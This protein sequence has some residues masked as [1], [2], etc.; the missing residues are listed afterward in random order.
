MKSEPEASG[1]GN[2]PAA[3]PLLPSSL[4]LA[5]KAKVILVVD[6]THNTR[7][8]LA[9]HLQQAGY[10]VWSAATSSEALT[11][12]AERGLPHL[13]VIDLQLGDR[14]GLLLAEL[15]QQ[16]GSLPVLFVSAPSSQPATAGVDLLF[17]PLSITQL[18]AR[19][20]QYLPDK[21]SSPLLG[22]EKSVDEHLTLNF[23]AH[24]AVL[25]Q[26]LI[27][28]TPAE[29]CLLALLFQYRGQVLSHHFLRAKLREVEPNA[30]RSVATYVYEL[31]QKLENHQTHRRY[32]RNVP[33]QG[34]VMPLRPNERQPAVRITI[35]G[36]GRA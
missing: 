30:R 21:L 4:A 36:R 11:V 25:G 13:V 23:A 9:F 12:V 22:Q 18:M 16:K 19:V 33:G 6:D 35:A 31:R 28:L 17:K 5:R 3:W 15:L 7:T 34:Y 32:I 14:S 24:Y 27:G 1:V 2:A 26:Q 8:F 10:T 29:S 20:Q